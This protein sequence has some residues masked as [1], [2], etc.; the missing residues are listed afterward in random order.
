MT[1]IIHHHHYHDKGDADR[2]CR[3]EEMLGTITEKME[4]IIMSFE[5]LK[6]AQ[7][8]TKALIGN[9]KADIEGLMA[10][11]DAFAA[12]GMTPDQVAEVTADAKAIN[13]QLSAAD[14]LNP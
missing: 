7:A 10:K 14:A 8:E 1:I 3:M 5:D 11:L 9:V 4:T 2:L 13:E 12:G 6:A